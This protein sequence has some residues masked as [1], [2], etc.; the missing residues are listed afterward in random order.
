VETRLVWKRPEGWFQAT[1]LWSSDYSSA[2]EYT[3]SRGLLIEGADPDGPLYEVPSSATCARCHAGAVDTLLGFEAINL[4]AQQADGLTLDELTRRELLTQNPD[5]A[6][7]VPGDPDAQASLGWLHANCGTVCHSGRIQR[8]PMGLHMRLQTGD[9]DSVEATAAWRTAVGQPS[10]YWPPL[11]C[12]R[13]PNR[14]LP[15]DPDCSTIVYRISVR[16]PYAGPYVN[17]MPPLLSHRVPVEAV[18]SLRRWVASLP[19]E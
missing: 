10:S 19:S 1:Y 5:R 3:G 4:S 8:G 18:E 11:Y 6:Y 17:Q 9:L 13:T 12:G 14:I 15:G 16:D 7:V 2:L